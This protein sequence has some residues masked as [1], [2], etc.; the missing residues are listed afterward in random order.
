MPNRKTRFAMGP[1]L[2]RCVLGGL[3]LSQPMWVAASGF[4]IPEVSVAGMGQSN[5]MVA[6]DEA[7]SSYGYNMAG[8]A[9]HAGTRASV[10][11]IWI[12][13]E[14]DVKPASSG[15]QVSSDNGTELV[16]TLYATHRLRDR[17]LAFGIGVNVPFGLKTDWPAGTFTVPAA[18]TDPTLSELQMVQ[19]NPA[20]AFLARPNLSVA[21]GVNYYSV[22]S[23]NLDVSAGALEGSGDGLG[24]SLALLYSSEAYNIGVHYRSPVKVDVEGRSS[25]LGDV[26]TEIEFPSIFQAGVMWRVGPDW[27]LELD[28]DRTGWSSFDRL[29]ISD[30]S[31]TVSNVYDWQDTLALRLGTTYRFNEALHLRAGY[32]YENSAQP[33]EKFSPRLPDAN[34]HVL[35]FGAKYQRAAWVWDVGL[36]YVML[37]NKTVSSTTSPTSGD[38][39]GTTVYNG[40]YDAKALLYGLSLSRDF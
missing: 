4:R 39:N 1:L 36:N 35:G 13:P 27:S 7:V 18:G 3:L 31:T 15:Q 23:A 26:R 29:D 40:D 8:M 9:F 21:L 11:G 20:V 5:A 19:V 30:G 17:P 37:G 33:D 38:Y 12:R 25:L 28:L 22:R 10:D 2:G 24:A 34:R 16:P 14:F 32:S 6:D